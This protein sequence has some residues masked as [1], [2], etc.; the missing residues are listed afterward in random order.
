MLLSSTAYLKIHELHKLGDLWLQDFHCLLIDLHSVWLLIT[1]HLC[2]KDKSLLS[3]SE[4]LA[5]LWTAT[6]TISSLFHNESC[7]H[8]RTMER[9]E[10]K[11]VLEAVGWQQKGL[12]LR[13]EILSMYYNQAQS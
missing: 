3:A 7:S 11:L 8:L 2:C 12:F 4:P 6:A 9:P 13:C 10:R 5:E 1:F